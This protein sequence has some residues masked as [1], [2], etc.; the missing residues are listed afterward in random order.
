MTP[1]PKLASIDDLLKGR[2]GELA[3]GDVLAFSGVTRVDEFIQGATKS[4]ISHVALLL[5]EK[6]GAPFLVLEATGLGV[7]L[8]PLEDSLAR[9]QA[10]HTCFYLPLADQYRPLVDAQKISAY[11][12]ANAFDRYNY[13]GVVEAGIYDLDHPLF[14]KIL[15]AFHGRSLWSRMIRLW[16]RLLGRM[17]RVWAKVLEHEPN[18]RR[19]FCSQL[20]TE[21]L[22]AF[23][24]V[25]VPPKAGLVV[26]VQVCWFDIY[27]GAYQLN[28]AELMPDPFRWGDAP[29]PLGRRDA[30]SPKAVTAAGGG[31]TL[32]RRSS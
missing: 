29:L 27:A 22:Q 19:L 31:R 16:Y 1:I 13:D 21:V 23:K 4:G 20:V 32:P 30:A 28:G 12:E 25:T 26:P 24:V 5:R 11:Y 6:P 3:V 8:T 10:D 2:C 18:Y 17:A 15:R 7:T 14:H 9:Y